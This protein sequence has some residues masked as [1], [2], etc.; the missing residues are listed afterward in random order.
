MRVNRLL[1]LAL[2]VLVGVIALGTTFYVVSA[3]SAVKMDTE[4]D[5]EFDTEIQL[6]VGG[7]GNM[8]MSMGAV[9]NFALSF[10]VDGSGNVLVDV[11]AMNNTGSTIESVTLGVVLR[12]ENGDPIAEE[13]TG[14][15]ELEIVIDGPVENQTEIIATAKAIGQCKE[16]KEIY[17]HS[18]TV[19]YSDGLSEMIVYKYSAK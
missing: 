10:D 5:T 15:A 16:V 9:D 14:K 12:D 6:N 13:S 1:A 17:V 11:S 19:T 2:C 8:N 3:N 4:V 18:L 7:G